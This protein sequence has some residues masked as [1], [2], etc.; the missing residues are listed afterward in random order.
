M[1]RSGALLEEVGQ[2]LK[3]HPA[4]EDLDTKVHYLQKREPLMQG[5]HHFFADIFG[6]ET[7]ARFQG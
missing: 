6:Q 1:H 2:L 5:A 7:T 3:D 4:V